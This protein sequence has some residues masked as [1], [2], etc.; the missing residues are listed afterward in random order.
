MRNP[1]IVTFE[2]L[3]GDGIQRSGIFEYFIDD[4]TAKKWV[5]TQHKWDVCALVVFHIGVVVKSWQSL[6]ERYPLDAGLGSSL[7]LPERYQASRCP[8]VAGA[9]DSRDVCLDILERVVVWRI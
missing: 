1:C 5:M 6:R 4:V 8:H 2:L 9:E 7:A 3:L